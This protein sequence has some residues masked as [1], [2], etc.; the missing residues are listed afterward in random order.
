MRCLQV[1]S[2][3]YCLFSTQLAGVAVHF[4]KAEW[5]QTDEVGAWQCLA[6]AFSCYTP[7]LCH[8]ERRLLL[9][10][11][12]SSS[13]CTQ[14]SAGYIWSHDDANPSPQ[15]WCTSLQAKP[16]ESKNWLRVLD[17]R[18]A[19]LPVT[20]PPSQLIFCP[21]GA[22]CP[23]H[24]QMFLRSYYKKCWKNSLW[25]SVLIISSHGSSHGPSTYCHWL[26]WCW[27]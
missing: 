20:S 3:F 21:S 1:S 6:P 25:A 14:I 19:A 7:C 12:K 8:K 5:M 10:L 2:R 16:T 13:E 27:E 11:P 26:D 22:V 24:L 15:C 18:L 9:T 4:L 23:L 17:S